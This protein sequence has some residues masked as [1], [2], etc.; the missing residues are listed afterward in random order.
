MFT[1]DWC[2]P[3]KAV[4]E[5]L[6]GSEVV[7]K[8]TSKGRFVFIDVDE[9]RG[10]AHQL[11]PGVNPR[12][13]PTLVS[14]DTQ[15]TML[16][17]VRGTELGLLSEK[18]TATNLKRLIQGKVPLPAS[19]EGNQEVRMQLIRE[20][21][22]RSRAATENWEPVDVKVVGKSPPK[23][24]WGS[25]KVDLTIRNKDSRRKWIAIGTPG[26][27]LAQE[28]AIESWVV[29]RFTEHVRAYSIDYVGYPSFRVV[30][31]GGPG[32][33]SL[34]GLDLRVGPGAESLEIWEL[35]T[36]EVDGKK[37]QFD[38]KVPYA[39]EVENAEETTVFMTQEGQPFIRLTP[40]QQHSIPLVR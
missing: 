31:I 21:A 37:Q 33:I 30:P 8:A 13:L 25:V 2:A 35:R 20:S 28:P 9:W 32:K 17:S 27:P 16:R 34:K 40:S 24:K 14:L 26:Q 10:P 29:R 19:Y 15:G 36:L 39:F 38:K 3:C 1:A 12:K 23:G 6:E 7:A 11:F 5:W 18:D 22:K 4:K